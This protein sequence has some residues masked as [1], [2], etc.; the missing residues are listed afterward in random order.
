MNRLL[1][2]ALIS[3]FGV[4]RLI[5]TV[6]LVI[7]MI[8][9]TMRRLG[10]FGADGALTREGPILATVVLTYAALICTLWW[11]KVAIGVATAALASSYWSDLLGIALLAVVASL[12]VAVAVLSARLA[13]GGPA[14]M[15]VVGVVIAVASGRTNPWLLA[16]T[17]VVTLASGLGF[18]VRQELQRVQHIEQRAAALQAAREL[19]VAQDRAKFAREL[20]DGVG[21]ALA[22][23]TLQCTAFGHSSDP[24]VL[25]R[26]LDKI[27]GLS[28]QGTTQM[29]TLVDNLRDVNAA[30]ISLVVAAPSEL[31]RGSHEQLSA[32]GWRVRGRIDARIDGLRAMHR[33][34]VTHFIQEATAN[35]IRYAEPNTPV[36]LEITT[37]DEAITCVAENEVHPT[38][39][40]ETRE[41]TG[42]G[43]VGLEE[44]ATQLG[45]SVAA[46]GTP[47]RWRLVMNVPLELP[48]APATPAA[49]AEEEAP[50]TAN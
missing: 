18:V 36:L 23:I 41:R 46:G 12:V 48:S 5:V 43:I 38:P 42:S 13:V 2:S 7:S 28:R 37:A 3:R 10:T 30:P 19:L 21:H 45:G 16:V 33:N 32:C 4:V 14:V 40:V 22:N 20:H 26:T 17:I 31:A 27:Q 44:L 35:I 6:V 29:R 24:E 34:A 8:D 49:P 11:P 39:Q 9:D 25:K 1:P 47:G 15:F 50:D